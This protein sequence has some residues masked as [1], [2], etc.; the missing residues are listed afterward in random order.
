MITSYYFK[1]PVSE[2]WEF[3]ET[4]FGNLNLLVGASGSGKTKFL[5]TVFN[6]SNFVCAG[7]PFRSGQWKITVK[8]DT[9]EYRWEIEGETTEKGANEIVHEK[10]SRTTLP[11]PQHPEVL[12]ERT[13]E[14]FTFCGAKLPKLSSDKP[15]INLLKEE[16]SIRPFYET[17][18][19]VQRR[20]FHDE[21]LRDALALQPIDPRQIRAI[22]SEGMHALWSQ[23]NALSAKMFLLKEHFERLYQLS[24]DTLKSIFPSIIECDVQIAKD[25]SV[26]IATS[27]IPVFVVKEKGVNRWIALHELSS[28]MQKVLLIITD[29]VS[30]PRGSIYI[31]D[32][33]ENSLGINAIDFLPQFLV[34]HGE[35]IQF[36][37]TTH[38]PYLI[39]NVPVRCWKI[40]HRTGSK[41]TVR[42]GREFEEKYSK[43]KQQAFTQL[44]N[45]P[46][47]AGTE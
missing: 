1:G 31:I 25:V 5:N 27:P 46:F 16:D 23:E 24:I 35:G 3:E 18:A 15:S 44:I 20:N 45:D 33:Y 30:L 38:H 47:Y 8:T 41:V 6:F 9:H 39:N 12:I 7:Q 4:K 34:D 40:F 42:D 22:R 10:L 29:I 17:F 37:I 13:R 11:S 21:G 19:R 14:L 36:L 26:K 28:G 2:P 32:E 43:S